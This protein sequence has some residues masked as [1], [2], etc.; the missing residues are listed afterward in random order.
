MNANKG[1]LLFRLSMGTIMV[2]HGLSKLL[3]GSMALQYVGGM[4]P[5]APSNPNAQLV[6][7]SIAAAFEILGGLGVLTGIGFRAACAMLVLVLL[8]ATSYHMTQVTN[9]SSLMMNTWPLELAFVFASF[10]FIGPGECVL[11][12]KCSC[13]WCSCG[14]G[15]KAGTE[16]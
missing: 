4:P 8:G 16:P 6:L 13:G 15:D 1:I 14:K 7:G 2:L 10:L 3:G 9:F 11:C 12:K 5:F